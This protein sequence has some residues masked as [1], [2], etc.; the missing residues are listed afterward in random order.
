MK[1]KSKTDKTPIAPSDDPVEVV[2]GGEALVDEIGEVRSGTLEF[3][4]EAGRK[5][6][7]SDD[8][9][10]YR[11]LPDDTAPEQKRSTAMTWRNE[12]FSH[13]TGIHCIGLPGAVYRT[14]R[15]NAERAS[16]LKLART[17]AERSKIEAPGDLDMGEGTVDYSEKNAG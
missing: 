8:E 9:F 10:S 3:I 14:T 13:V 6:G 16:A 5:R 17:K 2:P 7:G 11:V 12:G 15:A 1:K 4:D